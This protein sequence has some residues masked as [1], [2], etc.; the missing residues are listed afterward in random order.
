MPDLRGIRDAMPR[1]PL[2]VDARAH[3]R[4]AGGAEEVRGCSS[5]ELQSIELVSRL[6]SAFSLDERVPADVGELLQQLRE[7]AMRLA[8]RDPS[9]LDRLEHPLWRWIHLFAY[10]AEMVP[11]VHDA[12]RRRW[13]EFGRRTIDQLAA[14]P[15]QKGVIYREAATRLEAFLHERLAR[16][17]AALSRRLDALQRTEAGL[18]SRAG[19]AQDDE[20]PELDTVP[21]AL[22]TRGEAGH[23]VN[24]DDPQA[25]TRWITELVPGQW[26]RLLLDGAWVHAQLLWLGDRRQIM[27]LGHAVSSNT[28]AVR[29]ALLL[30]MYRHG[31]A[32]TL[33]MRS[34]V[35]TAALRVQEQLSLAIAAGAGPER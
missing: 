33:T 21:A 35:G 13:L 28:W 26:L 14:A 15:M 12:D 7:P 9:L 18:A 6:F 17:V 20:G 32:K 11:H 16:R 19:V 29:R 25:A 3:R 10:Q 34:L 31:L 23:P 1:H 27:L 5:V 4:H 2:T 8:L 30:R 22:I 24:E